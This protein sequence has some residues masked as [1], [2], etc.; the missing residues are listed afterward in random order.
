MELAEFL[1]R[2]QAD[3]RSQVEER[4]GEPGPYPYAESVFA[5]VVMDHMSDIGMT[6]DPAVCHYTAK[7]QKRDVAPQRV[8]GIG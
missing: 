3:V 2:T 8:R 1:R 4:R 5:E 6:S 7:V